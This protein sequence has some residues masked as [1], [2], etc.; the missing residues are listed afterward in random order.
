MESTLQNPAFV[1]AKITP[2]A[3]TIVYWVATPRSS[4]CR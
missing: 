1:V 3:K 2:N 4:A